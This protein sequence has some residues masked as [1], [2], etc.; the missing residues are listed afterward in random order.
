M[1]SPKHKNNSTGRNQ[2]IKSYGLDLIV[3]LL[4]ALLFTFFFSFKSVAQNVGIN[5]PAPHAKALLDLTSSDKGLLAPRITQAAR[6]AM[7]PVADVTAKGMIV[8]Q[9]DAIAGFYFYDGAAWNQLGNATDGWAKTGNSG[10]TPST[11]FI[12]TTDNQDLVVKT[13]NAETARFSATGKLGL[14]TNNPGSYY[15][16]ARMEIADETGNNSDFAMRVAAG[17]YPDFVFMKQRGTLST[18]AATVAGD[19][20]GL[21]SAWAYDGTKYMLG[22][23]ISFLV[24][25]NSAVN[26]VAGSIR[27]YSGNNNANPE[28]MRIS[29]NSNVG[30][31]AVANPVRKLD[32]N[33]DINFGNLNAI[34]QGNVK[35]LHDSGTQN[36]FIGKLTGQYMSTG[37]NVTGL[38]YLAG[39]QNT[40]GNNNTFIGA[41]AGVW[42]QT[43]VNNAYV[44]TACGQDAKGY[45]NTYMGA[46]AGANDSV[47]HD[48]SFFGGNAGRKNKTG[49]DNCFMGGGAGYNNLTGNEN[50]FLGKESGVSNT[51]GSSNAFVGHR[52]GLFNNGSDNTFVGDSAGW[53]N[54][55][56]NKNICIGYKSWFGTTVNNAMAIGANAVTNVSNSC[57][58]GDTSINVGIGY[59]DP[60]YPLHFQPKV[61]DKISLWGAGANHYGFGIQANQ[62]QIHCGAVVDDIV[63]GYGS[64]NALTE[65]MRIKGNGKVGIGTSKPGAF[66]SVVGLEIAD[67]TGMNRDVMLRSSSNT[68]HSSL[69]FARTRGSHSTPAIVQPNED[70]G[71][72]SFMGYDGTMLMTAAEIQG[73]ADST[74]A[75]N[76]MPGNLT[77]HTASPT[78]GIGV[79]ERMRIDRNGNIGVGTNAPLTKLDV[80]GALALGENASFIATAASLTLTIGNRS[81]FRVNANDVPSLRILTLSNGLQVGQI[82]II[83]CIAGAGTGFRI[84]DNA[85][86]NNTNTVTNRDM[87][88]GDVITMIWNGNDWMEMSF[89]D[90]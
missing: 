23:R 32:V 33:G 79:I 74:A 51:A 56:G 54:T 50:M 80:E 10:T 88:F 26:D 17:G 63:F 30:I 15:N 14:G 53:N 3:G 78:S 9:T 76:S 40:T 58:I 49:Y 60:I 67:S 8:Y 6:V 38:G 7:F 69:L 21:I 16:S 2:F 43:G 57:V 20:N 45:W 87:L 81:Y 73:H 27:F 11:N 1:E 41:W 5:N 75:T 44:G 90:N 66:Y 85:A 19:G 77:F 35:L 83:E 86:V 65:R 18:P 13:N 39:N 47:G 55:G 62:L 68:T 89:A 24:D 42:N 82:L 46:F 28:V 70:L 22:S 84:A 31:G 64:S 37:Y 12:G 61:G 52:A 4:L 59:S 48:N 36:M 71:R 25:S 72:V 29:S 34:Y